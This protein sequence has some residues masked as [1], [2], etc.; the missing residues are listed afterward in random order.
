MSTHTTGILL[1]YYERYV[2]YAIL[3]FDA[4]LHTLP[5]TCSM[6]VVHNG[7]T[8]I[9][10]NRPGLK[11]FTGDNSVREFSG[12]EVGLAHCRHS[13]LLEKSDLVV[14]AN[15]TFCHHNK[16]GSVTRFAFRQALCQLLR[17]PSAPVVAGVIHSFGKS[18]CIDGL[19]LDRW[20]A[21]YLF[22][23]SRGMLHQLHR[24][25]PLTQMADFY[26]HDVDTLNF[27]DRVSPNLASHVKHW[28]QGSGRT[29]MKGTD[30]IG[31]LTLAQLQGKS[32]SILCEKYLSAYALAQ[33]GTLLDVFESASLRQLRRVEALPKKW[34]SVFGSQKNDIY[35]T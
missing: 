14:F 28:L 19:E 5:G 3:Q 9:K 11:I 30:A 8:P 15:D 13:G 34:V 27:S 4:F 25:M 33:G 10:N 35:S 7:P 32:N 1:T 29:R 26:C 21:T 31:T 24:L 23:L 2:D 22:G 18:F 12:W 16:F 6:I 20:V 17:L